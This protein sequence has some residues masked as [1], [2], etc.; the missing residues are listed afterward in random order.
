[1]K[2]KLIVSLALL[3]VF[4]FWASELML[5][6]YHFVP[7]IGRSWQEKNYIYTLM[8]LVFGV[9]T[10]LEWDVLFPDRR[11]FVNLTP[12]PVRLRTVFSAKLASFI[13]FVALFST[14]MMSLSSVLFSIYLT[15]WRAESV[16]PVRALCRR[17][18]RGGFRGLPRRLLRRRPP[19]G[20]AGRVPARGTH[21]RAALVVRFALI[22]GLLFLLFSFFAAPS[23]VG[24]AFQDLDVLKESRHPFVFRF[25]PLW[26]V[27][28]YEV[29]LGTRDS[30]F[31]AQ[32]RTAGLAVALAAAAFLG[33]ERPELPPPRRQDPRGPEGPA[34]FFPGPRFLPAAYRCGPVPGARGAGRPR[35]LL[36][37]AEIEP[38]SPDVARLLPGRRDGARLHPPRRQPEV[39]ADPDAGERALPR[40]PDPPG[41]YRPGR[42]PGRRR[43][44]GRA[45]GRMDL[46]ADRDGPDR[47]LRLR[48]QERPSSSDSSSRCSS[49]SSPSTPCSGTL[50]RPSSTPFSGWS[51]RACAPKRSFYRYRKVP[52]ACSWVPGKLK[53]QFTAVPWLIGILLAGTALAAVER[54]ILAGP[55]RGLVFLGVAAAAWGALRAGNRRFYRENGLLYEEE[56][57]AAMIGFPAAD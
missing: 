7:D 8:M 17:P 45:R 57:E 11:D 30:V 13:L 41:L 6:K 47:P 12:L 42:G 25:P 14:A 18:P 32:A 56:P 37:H 16:A 33:L 24:R 39:L 31:E 3:A 55:S 50:G 29:L 38:A 27:G 44:A 52:F 48:P 35:L 10:L 19:P 4:F 23:I 5:F 51:F 21:K 20:P 22:A 40:S 26:F 1:M 9:V 2:E 34:G 28:L 54:S 15:Q 46:P 43:P 53:L 36:R 49:V